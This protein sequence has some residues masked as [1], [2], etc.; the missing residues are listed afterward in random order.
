MADRPRLVS[1]WFGANPQFERLAH[2]LDFTARKF[3]PGW[4]VEVGRI[5]PAP[6]RSPL[7][8]ASHAFNTQKMDAWAAVIA[9]AEEG[10]RVL[11]IDADTMVLRSLDDVWANEF[12]LAY[13]V[14]ASA[15]RFPFNSGVVFFRVSEATRRFAAAWQ[16][17]NV[18]L[19]ESPKEH[20]VWRSKYGG[21]NQAAL[22]AMLEGGV[23][24]RLGLRVQALPCAE[25]NC[26][27]SSWP[28]FSPERTRIVH[29]K[30]ALRRGVFSLGPMTIRL[31]PLVNLWR[32]FERESFGGVV[33]E[34]V[35]PPPRRPVLLVRPRRSPR[36]RV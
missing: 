33:P 7:G 22:G 12:D 25:W 32:Q 31:R 18:R 4:D 1:H 10:A 6:R 36:T 21:C 14:K 3:C 28:A 30:S 9:E 5:E 11:L 35:A 16:A 20:V 29:L 27:D 15:I 19:L 17:E 24:A 23:V 26:E 2:V 34:S 13:T 8:V